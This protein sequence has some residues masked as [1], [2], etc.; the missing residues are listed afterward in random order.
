DPGPIAAAGPQQVSRKC[1]TCEAKEMQEAQPA[2][3]APLI[4]NRKCAAC[5]EHDKVQRTGA[6]GSANWDGHEAPDSVHGALAAPGI[7]LDRDA[8]AFFEPRF[9]RDFTA[10]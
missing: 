10:V 1:V 5:E 2:P 7:P 6:G 4:V 8:R 9:G 3:I